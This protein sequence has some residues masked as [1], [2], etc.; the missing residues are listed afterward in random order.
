MYIRPHHIAH[1]VPIWR[2]SKKTLKELFLQEIHD[3]QHFIFTK[4]AEIILSEDMDAMC[5]SPEVRIVSILLDI[6]KREKLTTDILLSFQES[7]H[8]KNIPHIN[9]ASALW[10]IIINEIKNE[11]FLNN[12][13]NEKIKR[14]AKGLS[15]DTDHVAVFSPYCDAIITE[16]KMALFLNIA[17]KENIINYSPK[18]FSADTLNELNDYLANLENSI[19][20]EMKEELD[21]AYSIKCESV[22]ENILT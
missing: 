13:K 14:Q 16:K 12:K 21:L 6:I 10:A 17:K 4:A 3:H 9:I 8:F 2:K 5:N 11:R 15:Y 19:S 20:S 1:Q 22:V 18:I 7:E